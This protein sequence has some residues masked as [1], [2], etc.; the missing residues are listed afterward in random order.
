MDKYI[1]KFIE[2]NNWVQYCN[3]KR[4]ERVERLKAEGVLNPWDVV[5]GKKFKPKY[6]YV[7]KINDEGRITIP[8]KIRKQLNI[9]PG[10]LYQ[11]KVE[12]ENIILIAIK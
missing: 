5:K 10:S 12:G 2:K 8:S 6:E 11:I 3:Q 4:K 7:R 9:G 1:K